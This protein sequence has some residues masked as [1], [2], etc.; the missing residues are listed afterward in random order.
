MSSEVST[1]SSWFSVLTAEVLF[2]KELNSD[3]KILVAL[4]SNGMNRKGYCWSSNEYFAEALNCSIRTIQRNLEVLEAAG[5]LSRVINI[6]PETKQVKERVL[7]V[8]ER[9]IIPKSHMTNLT[10]GGDSRDMTPHDTGVMYN[11]RV[12]NNIENT[13][14]D[15]TVSISPTEP[16]EEQKQGKENLPSK[17]QPAEGGKKSP[18]VAPTPPAE[19][20]YR[21]EY[22]D[23]QKT[24]DPAKLKDNVNKIKTF[25]AEHKGWP[26]P[27][28]Y[29]DLWNIFAHIKKVPAAQV[30]NE[31]RK[32]KISSRVRETAFDFPAIIDKAN[33]S[34]FLSGG[35][36]WTATFDWLIE[37][38]SN[39][40]KV[41]EGNYN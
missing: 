38:D 2:D 7:M 10:G 18:P 4:I 20:F 13:D 9:K 19:R 34:A 23:V 33:N 17:N 41:L 6:D 24:F 32:R 26:H 3:Q 39:Y 14:T 21:K 12:S 1:Q 22:E 35:S 25:L 40:V 29:M 28:P 11:N 37:N 30:A 31:S 15:L 8:N 36:G 5:Y 16:A 27:E